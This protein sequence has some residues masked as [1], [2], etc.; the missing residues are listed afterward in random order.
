MHFERIRGTSTLSEEI[1]R[2]IENEIM[3]NNLHPGD[4]LPTET[5]LSEMFGVSRTSVREATQMLCAKGFLTIK[6]GRGTFVSELSSETMLE[7]MRTFMARQFDDEWALDIMKVRLLIEPDCARNAA[8]NP[9]ASDL[10]AL[11]DIIDG[12]ADCKPDD[13]ETLGV[14]ERRFHLQISHMAGNP[15]IPLLMQPIF[16]SMPII[17]AHIYEVILLPEDTPYKK[18]R[19]VYEA[20]RDGKPDEA[21][22]MMVK[23]LEDAITEAKGILDKG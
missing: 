5:E 19:L 21:Y 10:E 14:L 23:H 18:H 2:K 1:S 17:K 9:S 11:K 15:V 4:R 7:A 16:E 13:F 3:N 22:N 8:V 6:K 12:F 20:I